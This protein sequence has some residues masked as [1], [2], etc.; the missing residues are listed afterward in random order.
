MAKGMLT[1][2]T[3]KRLWAEACSTAVY[4]KNRLPHSHLHRITPYEALYKRK[5]I[6]RYLQP[7][8]QQCYIHIYEDNRSS[9]SKLYPR[10]E[11][12]T[13]GTK[14]WRPDALQWRPD[15]SGFAAASRGARTFRASERH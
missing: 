5:P 9:G 8:G 2:T 10:A 6:I 4:L 14:F 3:D 7:F 15:A 11:M 1:H 12:A 13:L